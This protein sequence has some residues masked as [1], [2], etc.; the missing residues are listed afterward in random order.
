MLR[1][2]ILWVVVKSHKITHNLL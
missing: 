2:T 1:K